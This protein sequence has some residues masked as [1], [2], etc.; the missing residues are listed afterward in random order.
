MIQIEKKLAT[1]LFNYNSDLKDSQKLLLRRH[2]KIN[3]H[4]IYL[5]KIICWIVQS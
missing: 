3:Q 5:F 1:N 4:H 2:S